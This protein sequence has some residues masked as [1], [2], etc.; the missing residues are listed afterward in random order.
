MKF[1]FFAAGKIF[2]LP[3]TLPHFSGSSRRYFGTSCKSHLGWV[4]CLG[5]R[6]LPIKRGFN[7]CYCC[8]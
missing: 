2:R 7:N 5:I 1:L 6:W 4:A 3:S 8:R